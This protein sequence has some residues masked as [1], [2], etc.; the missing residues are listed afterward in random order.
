M[1]SSSRPRSLVR[2]LGFL[3]MSA[4]VALLA[5]TSAYLPT[6]AQAAT[7]KPPAATG[8]PSGIESLARYV[9]ANSCDPVAQPGTVK[10]AKLLTATYPGTSYGVTR[11][12]GTDALPTSEHYDG[13][14]IDW[15]NSV[16][17][18]KQADQA[19]AVISW[20]TAT[21]ADGNT[22]ANAR[23]LGVMYVIWNNKIWGAYSTD[24]G[25][26]AYSSCATHPEKSWDST[27]HRNHMHISLSWE[28][29]MGA[30]SYWT[31]SVATPDYGSCRPKDLNWAAPYTKANPNRCPRYATVKAPK[32][33][34]ATL[35]TLTTYSG[36]ELRTGSTGPVVKAVQKVVK[37]TVSGKYDAKTKAAV[38]KWQTAHDLKANG[39]VNAKTWRAL[40]KAQAPK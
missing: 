22:Y 11:T 26:R 8:L 9:P 40:L 35:K 24:R 12:C 6:T 20:L 17:N 29:A 16:R 36:M 37:T 33:A 31:K 18:K 27:C 4:L 7:K 3:L 39:V 5:V 14:A 15:M 21:D 28:G 25:W 32:G 23:R 38:K 34:S 13:R 2:R 1:P 19:K 30:T 10:F